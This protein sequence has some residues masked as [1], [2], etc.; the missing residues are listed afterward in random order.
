MKF[1]ILEYHGD[2]PQVEWKK[3]H[4]QEKRNLTQ[5]DISKLIVFI[6]TFGVVLNLKWVKRKEL[7]I[8]D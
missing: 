5:F 7:F 6:A 3:I 2:L 4:A 1:Y 8:Y